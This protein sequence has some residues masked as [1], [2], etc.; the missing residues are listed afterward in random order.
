MEY[1]LLLL[2]DCEPLEFFVVSHLSTLQLSRSYYHI[3]R[4][5]QAKEYSVSV[6]A[7]NPFCFPGEKWT[8]YVLSVASPP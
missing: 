8:T 1:I 3:A 6:T 7:A 5:I 4:K 2:I